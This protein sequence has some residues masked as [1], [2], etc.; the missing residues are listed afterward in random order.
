MAKGTK[1]WLTWPIQGDVYAKI[2]EEVVAHST[3]DFEE[4]GVGS[5]TLKE[6][7]AVRIERSFSCLKASQELRER[8]SRLSLSSSKA[9][10]Q[11]RSQR[12]DISS[13]SA[14]SRRQAQLRAALCCTGAERAEAGLED[15]KIAG[16][17]LLLA[18]CF[19]APAPAKLRPL[20]THA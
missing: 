19:I 17:R 14:T 20:V 3:T 15:R 2:I 12:G 9:H 18:V 11:E 6:L 7:Q 1:A 10:P 13:S 8:R 16:P 4:S 5:T